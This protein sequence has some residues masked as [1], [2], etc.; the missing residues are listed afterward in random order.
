MEIF[1]YFIYTE[2]STKHS[3]IAFYWLNILISNISSTYL[4]WI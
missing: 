3:N 1:L 2:F 4:H